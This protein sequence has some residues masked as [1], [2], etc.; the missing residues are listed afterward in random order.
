MTCGAAK[1]FLGEVAAPDFRGQRLQ[2]HNGEEVDCFEFSI[3]S[4]RSANFCAQ[5]KISSEELWDFDRSFWGQGVGL[6]ERT[7][8]SGLGAGLKAGFGKV[9]GG[10][11]LECF[12]AVMGVLACQRAATDEESELVGFGELR[13]LLPQQVEDDQISMVFVDAGSA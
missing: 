6:V 12:P 2:V 4:G 9:I 10:Q 3:Q 8:E 5:R 13:D 7:L 1:C 11:S